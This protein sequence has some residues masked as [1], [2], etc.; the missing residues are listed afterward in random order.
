MAAS[1]I[2]PVNRAPFP[3]TN[4]SNA[5]FDRAKSM[6]PATLPAAGIVPAARELYA[7]APAGAPQGVPGSALDPTV[8]TGQRA[9]GVQAAL[10]GRKATE[11]LRR[12]R[13][14][15][16]MASPDQRAK[17]AAVG[18]AVM[19]RAAQMPQQALEQEARLRQMLQER[20]PPMPDPNML[21]RQRTLQNYVGNEGL[22][23]L[24]NRRPGLLEF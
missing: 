2:V 1:A 10:G 11:D 18:G 6:P 21:D 19:G 8:A 5:A 22:P 20:Q 16:G 9:L 17:M 15:I 13:M 12:A 24:N 23:F 4:I 7:N 14:A 3:Q